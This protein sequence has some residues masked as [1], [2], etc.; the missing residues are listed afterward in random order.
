[1]LNEDMRDLADKFIAETGV[2]IGRFYI[3]VTPYSEMLCFTNEDGREYD[4]PISDESL[5][6]AVFSRL[7]ELGV[8]V[9]EIK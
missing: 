8:R 5:A 4:L 2:E 7:R 6:D 3:E 1:M 9:E